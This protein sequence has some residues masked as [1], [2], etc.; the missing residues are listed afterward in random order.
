MTDDQP[1]PDIQESARI[2]RAWADANPNDIPPADIHAHALKVQNYLRAR[3]ASQPQRVDAFEKF[4]QIIRSDDP[5]KMPAW[6]R[7]AI[8]GTPPPNLERA[9]ERF[10]RQRLERSDT[11]APAVPWSDPRKPA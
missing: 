7:D 8:T 10:A 2:F 5:Q 1:P 3:G 9:F 6:S 4:K 11:P